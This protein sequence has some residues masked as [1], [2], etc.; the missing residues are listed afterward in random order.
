[1]ATESHRNNVLFVLLLIVCSA[2]LMLG[3]TALPGL[4]DEVS[5]KI[6]VNGS[7]TTKT[8]T[9]VVIGASYAGGWKP[10]NPVAGYQ[11][12]NKGV[13][14]QQSFEML[15]RFETDVVAHKPDAVIIWGFIN[16]V[17]RNDRNRMEETLK[18]T[19]ESLAAM[20]ESARKA[21]IRPI[22]ATE[23]TI[24][25]KAGFGEAVSALVGSLL[26]KE[27]YQDYIN[28]QVM[29]T[30]RWIKELA[31]HEGIVLL[32][33]EAV[34]GD[35]SGVRKQEFAEADGSH[36]S[37][38]GYLAITEYTEWQLNGMPAKR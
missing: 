31:A 13:D 30:N 23:V 1:M 35:R 15:A 28:G 17:F 12:I 33:Y 3:Y 10:R 4:A 36:I 11:V 29:Q 22:L 25:G 19:R 5:R 8:K 32:D 20:V 21:G 27:S 7:M 9:V 34:L 37:D 18:H 26:G 38:A 14:G 6:A 24:R 2:A 16:D